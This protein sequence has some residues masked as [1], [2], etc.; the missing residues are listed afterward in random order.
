MA[1]VFISCPVSK[2]DST[3]LKVSRGGK[4]WGGGMMSWE[5]GG[6]LEGRKG[7]LQLGFFPTWPPISFGEAALIGRHLAPGYLNTTCL[8]FPNSQIG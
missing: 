6:T 2:G 3:V 5:D 4:G 1:H 7:H 8:S